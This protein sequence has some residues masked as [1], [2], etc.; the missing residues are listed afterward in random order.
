MRNKFHKTIMLILTFGLLFLGLCPF[1]SVNAETNE[2][3]EKEETI[4]ED[5]GED[6]E[7]AA[8]EEFQ[9]TEEAIEPQTVVEEVEEITETAL[10]SAHISK[11]VITASEETY[12]ITVTFEEDANIPEDADLSVVEILDDDEDYDSYVKESEIALGVD[13][14]S[15]EYVRMFD[16]TIIDGAGN[17]IEPDA[18]V[19]VEIKLTDND[20][21]ELNIVHFGD[22]TEVLSSDTAV[23]EEETVVTFQT[24][25][26]SIYTVVA[27]PDDSS[28]V[29]PEEDELGLNGK[30]F[31]M[32]TPRNPNGQ[33]YPVAVMAVENTF[34]GHN[35]LET[36]Q[37][38]SSLNDT[39]YGDA[40]R[41]VTEWLF[42]YVGMDGDEATYYLSAD[43]N[44]KTVY[45]T[46]DTDTLWEAWTDPG[47][48]QNYSC[49]LIL[50]EE[51]QALVV[52]SNG[53]NRYIISAKKEID[54]VMRYF[55]INQDANNINQGFVGNCG[56]W[57]DSHLRLCTYVP[58]DG[59]DNLNG[60]SVAIL[61]NHRKVTL[62]AMGEKADASEPFTFQPE[63]MK[64]IDI[65]N[66]DT[67][68]HADIW[69]FEITQNGYHL[70]T[71]VNGER[72]YLKFNANYWDAPD[73]VDEADADDFV[74]A[75]CGDGYSIKSYQ[76]NYYLTQWQGE[77]Y[78]N[79]YR[80]GGPTTADGNCFYF[81]T[82]EE[83]YEFAVFNPYGEGYAN[84]QAVPEN[85]DDDTGPRTAASLGGVK[86]E[87]SM[88]GSFFY[89]WLENDD[90]DGKPVYVYGGNMSADAKTWVFEQLGNDEY[91]I[92]TYEG[93]NRRYLLLD[94]NYAN[95][96]DSEYYFENK[97]D[98]R[99]TIKE[100][101]NHY[102]IYRT[103]GEDTY[104]LTLQQVIGGNDFNFTFSA[105]ALKE[106][107]DVR[108][109]KFIFAERGFEQEEYKTAE[110]ISA[111]DDIDSGTKLVLYCAV[112]DPVT[113]QETYYAID[114]DGNAVKIRNDGSSVAY[115]SED[116]EWEFLSDGLGEGEYRFV[117]QDGKSIIP[118]QD[119]FIFESED[120]VSLP[121][122]ENGSYNTQILDS[123]NN[124]YVVGF[125]PELGFISVPAS[126]P[127]AADIKFASVTG[128]KDF[129]AINTIET[130]DSVSDGIT[131][132]VY[133]YPHIWGEW[134]RTTVLQDMFGTDWEFG[135]SHLGI[136]QPRVQNGYPVTNAGIPI[137]Y[138]SGAAET[139]ESSAAPLFSDEY[140]IGDANH[141]FSQAEFDATGYYHYRSWDNYAYYDKTTGDFIVYDVVGTPSD[142][143]EHPAYSHGNFTPL[144]DLYE[145]DEDGNLV[146]DGDNNPIIAR[147]RSWS[148]Y[149][150]FDDEGLQLD[151]DDPRLGGELYLIDNPDYFFSM[152]MGC[153]FT[154]PEDGLAKGNHMTLEYNGDDDAWVFV[155]GVLLLDIGGVH[156][157]RAAWIDFATGDIWQQDGGNTTIRQRYLD[158]GYTEAECDAIFEEYEE[159]KYR[160]RDDT[161][162]FM[163]MYYFERG[164]G[165]S[166]LD[167]RF[168]LAINDFEKRN[169]TVVTRTEDIEDTEKEFAYTV[170]ASNKDEPVTGV[171]RGIMHYADGTSEEIQVVLDQEGKTYFNLK[172]DEYLTI[173][174]LPKDT[175]YT[176]TQADYRD[177]GISTFW[178]T[179][180]ERH[181]TP[182][183]ELDE[184]DWTR[185]FVVSGTLDIDR[186]EIYLN[187]A[188]DY[189]ITVSKT[190]DGNLASR[191]K[192]FTFTLTGDV[193]NCT[194]EINGEPG[195]LTIDGD[196]ATFTLRHGDV[197]VISGGA[198]RTSYTIS[199]NDYSNEGYQ[200]FMDGSETEG[201]EKTFVLDKDKE[202]SYLNYNNA[203]IPIGVRTRNPFSPVIP[204]LVGIAIYLAKS[205]R[206]RIKKVA[207][208]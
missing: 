54:G 135:R 148:N 72:K 67:E 80:N 23:E 100:E 20:A 38:L 190:V 112:S 27:L 48:P 158:A 168:N 71:T 91:T 14:G 78:L 74:I 104:Y 93:G 144:D 86:S 106:G 22:T 13:E 50:S 185:S 57:T 129:E 207:E 105:E 124:E 79:Q 189:L 163:N 130:V 17:E 147:R 83:L 188:G 29:P 180:E 117:S 34:N 63:D 102:Y 113:K 2:E 82:L 31:A 33:A 35:I 28:I 194:I 149:T 111:S 178:N 145:R 133:D 90:P 186:T 171:Y 49:P 70:Y 19:T 3:P 121:G 46:M 61:S 95:L 52:R 85:E 118:A 101:D 131:I 30:H 151:A 160:Y 132:S 169:L 97:E 136:L 87:D 161:N 6:L 176:V 62:N 127:R 153:E 196:T 53:A 94:D 56:G 179:Q 154:Q 73:L 166:H 142:T 116:V 96:K 187:K 139:Q 42:T 40:D 138:G 88:W 123:E 36:S 140:K 170:E 195:T 66:D 184:K 8:P 119:G 162:H 200:T 134:D 98:F 81:V 193:E 47:Q 103:V 126:D 18:P 32:A 84:E 122:R 208:E 152:V 51:P 41:Y 12:E 89:V 143:N 181:T 64:I 199:E 16:I 39:I 155:D 205:K 43:A 156:D 99:I 141:L 128:K 192:Q 201:R 175:D 26:F 24:E 77:G 44:G 114:K 1:T 76:N 25:G 165:A 107:D 164:A 15:A 198:S 7:D 204:V 108:F 60:L 9:E 150:M 92:S 59:S 157:P 146:L 5:V 120:T 197:A 10:N 203:S 21:E 11:S 172:K 4:I 115:V 167:I 110:K 191:A 177:E 65:V 125:D 159:G 109:Q 182:V 37:A 45:L 137:H 68:Q 55:D 183:G 58:G 69:T 202:F 206:F 174:G 75:P 173:L